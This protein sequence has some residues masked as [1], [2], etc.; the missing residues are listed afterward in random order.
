MQSYTIPGCRRK[1]RT[2]AQRKYLVVS[3]YDGRPKVE[4]STDDQAA[5]ARKLAEY[6]TYF[7]PGGRLELIDQTGE[8]A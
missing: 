4:Y 3:I 5:A 8:W 2:S 6:R 1:L 7:G